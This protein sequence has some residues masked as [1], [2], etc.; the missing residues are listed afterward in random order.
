MVEWMRTVRVKLYGEMLGFYRNAER[1]YYGKG[2]YGPDFKVIG[3]G[4]YSC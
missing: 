3:Q 1:E 4:E 2:V